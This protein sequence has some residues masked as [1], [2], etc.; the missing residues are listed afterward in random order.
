MGDEEGI[1][2]TFSDKNGLREYDKA[3]GRVQASANI[4]TKSFT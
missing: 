2:K 1:N 3:K 4:L